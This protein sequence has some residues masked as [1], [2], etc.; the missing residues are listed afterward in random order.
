MCNGGGAGCV[1]VT[2]RRSECE[3]E[4]M[5]LQ[6]GTRST[7][8][9]SGKGA[10]QVCLEARVAVE[11]EPLPLLRLKHHTSMRFLRLQS[12]Q[13]RVSLLVSV[14]KDDEVDIV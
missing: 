5:G 14:E 6:V 11:L 3:R 4:G 2:T 10:N 1:G 12:L 7:Q 8:E 9:R 13:E